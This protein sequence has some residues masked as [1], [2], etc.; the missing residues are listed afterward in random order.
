MNNRCFWDIGFENI[1]EGYLIS[2]SVTET[3]PGIISFFPF[4]ILLVLFIMTILLLL[5]QI[6]KN[7]SQELISE[8]NKKE[9]C[10]I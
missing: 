8:K 1:L 9:R 7:K 6:L 4:F 10:I 2:Y 3:V 5:L